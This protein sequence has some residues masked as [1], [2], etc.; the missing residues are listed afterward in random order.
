MASASTAL[1]MCIIIADYS[2]HRVQVFMARGKYIRQFGKKGGGEGQLDR[3][4]GIAIDS[5]DT[6]CISEWGN[7]RISLF[8]RD[9]HFLRSFGTK[10]KGPEQFN[11]P[12]NVGIDKDDKIC[13]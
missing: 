3:P 6:V 7:H 11:E 9:G 12:T 13:H 8:T 10:E 1:A 2:N 5:S 4:I